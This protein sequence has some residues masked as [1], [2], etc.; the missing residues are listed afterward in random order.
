MTLVTTEL[1]YLQYIVCENVERS[2]RILQEQR[3]SDESRLLVSSDVGQS[4][5]VGVAILEHCQVE[6]ENQE[7][8]HQITKI[9]RQ[10]LAACQGLHAGKCVDSCLD[11]LGFKIVQS[12]EE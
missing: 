9:M 12:I 10:V 2:Y 1:C 6:K 11:T 7:S 5:K 3:Q 4:E 8:S